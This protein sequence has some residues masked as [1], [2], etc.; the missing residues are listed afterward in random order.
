MQIKKNISEI[1]LTLFIYYATLLFGW[2]IVAFIYIYSSMDDLIIAER[3]EQFF[4]Y[5]PCL[6]GMGLVLTIIIDIWSRLHDRKG[7]TDLAG[8]RQISK[9]QY[10]YLLLLL[11]NYILFEVDLHFN[12]LELITFFISL[13]LLKKLGSILYNPKK[14]GWYHPTTHGSLYIAAILIGCSLLDI[15]NLT[16]IQDDKLVYLILALLTFEL[17]ILYARFQYLSKHSQE[18][19]RLARKLMGSQILFFGTRIIVGIF[20]PMIFIVYSTF[21]YENPVEGIPV[22]IL[23]GTFLERYLFVLTGSESPQ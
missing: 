7:A 17:I 2:Q 8:L 23:V 20:M 15:F 11:S 6:I 22:L 4:R 13:W 1:T 12:V 14:P 16:K 18:T 3:L 9:I 21:L 5:Q 10:G 19:N